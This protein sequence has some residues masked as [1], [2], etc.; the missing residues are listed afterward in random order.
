MIVLA[1]GQLRKQAQPKYKVDV[2]PTLCDP[3]SH[4]GINMAATADQIKVEF[5]V[6]KQHLRHL[7]TPTITSTLSAYQKRGADDR[8]RGRMLWEGV[9]DDYRRKQSPANKVS[10][11]G[12][13]DLPPELRNVI[14]ELC[15][16]DAGELRY[17]RQRARGECYNRPPPRHPRFPSAPSHSCTTVLDQRPA[18]YTYLQRQR[19]IQALALLD[20]ISKDKLDQADRHDILAPGARHAYEEY[21]YAHDIS[22]ARCFHEEYEDDDDVIMINE[23][24][25]LCADLPSIAIAS[26]KVL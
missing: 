12:F 5:D 21:K 26:R 7:K 2:L 20:Q 14:Y 22:T 13:L 18:A 15:V 8:K 3:F 11:T 16:K 24:G 25:N 6:A 4:D 9:L 23:R 17:T 10:G 1:V 19:H